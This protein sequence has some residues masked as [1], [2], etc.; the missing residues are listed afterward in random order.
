M[1]IKTFGDY[2]TVLAE[3]IKEFAREELEKNDGFDIERLF[4][5]EGLESTDQYK[6]V[7]LKSTKKDPST[8]TPIEKDSTEYSKEFEVLLKRKGFY[9]RTRNE[10]KELLSPKRDQH[11]NNFFSRSSLVKYAPYPEPDLYWNNSYNYKHRKLDDN[12]YE[13][14]KLSKRDLNNLLINR[15]NAY[16]R[17]E[18]NHHGRHVGQVESQKEDTGYVVPEYK[19]L[20]MQKEYLSIEEDYSKI[21]N[22]Y[23]L[24]KSTKLSQ[25]TE[26]GAYRDLLEK[27]LLRQL[28]QLNDFNKTIKKVLI[29]VYQNLEKTIF[30]KDGSENLEEYNKQAQDDWFFC[31][32]TFK[33]IYD[34]FYMNFTDDWR[35][36]FH[37]KE[38]KRN[39]YVEVSEKVDLID[40]LEVSYTQKKPIITI[41]RKI[42][43][44]LRVA[45]AIIEG[46]IIDDS[47]KSL[48]DVVE[49]LTYSD[50]P[51][52]R[53][54]A[55]DFVNRPGNSSGIYD[56]DVIEPVMR[57]TRKYI[58]DNNV[59]DMH[60]KLRT[61][62]KD[63]KNSKAKIGARINYVKFYAKAAGRY[64]V[65][66]KKDKETTKSDPRT[67]NS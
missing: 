18:I 13:E 22:E 2:E 37:S 34:T 1:K 44:K 38:I 50:L 53:K 48:S 42:A 19:L 31:L 65:R 20:K 9:G 59:K 26:L 3:I 64:K 35:L 40:F 54:V 29:T 12:I 61:V 46:L 14:E 62:A 27:Q 36:D 17:L 4:D 28:G 52:P 24:E 7:V 23:E 8:Y 63:I 10:L 11:L 32:V 16:S 66:E 56:V 67:K 58:I 25:I 45:E 57:A 49:S 21:V 55:K 39:P 43:L 15:F 41:A 5:N 47:L 51:S 60:K 6:S 30:N 33:T